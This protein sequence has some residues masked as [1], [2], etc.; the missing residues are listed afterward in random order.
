MQPVFFNSENR[1][2]RM[3]LVPE[4]ERYGREDCLT[5]DEV[6]P[7]VEFYDA[8]QDPEKFGERGQFVARY[9]LSTLRERDGAL[10]LCLD[11]GI[12]SWSVDAAF[13]TQVVRWL[14][15]EGQWVRGHNR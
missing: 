10:G 7:L 3:R 13:M 9:Y 14:E 15:S 1:P 11:G 8:S 12:P 6:D 4:G 2:F 5:H